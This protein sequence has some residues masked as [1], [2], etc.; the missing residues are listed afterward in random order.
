MKAVRIFIGI[1][2]LLPVNA[3]PAYE[4]VE[5]KDGGTISGRV[6][7]TGT[8]PEIPAIRVVKNPEFCGS[9][10]RD[11]VLTVHPENGGLKNVIVYLQGI[12]RGKPLP[13][14]SAVNAFK[15]LFVPYSSVVLR[16][17]PVVFHNNDTILHNA[18]AYNDRG[19]TLFNVALPGMGRDVKKTIKKGG[20]IQIQCDSHV[21][22]NGWAISLDHPYFSV[23]DDQ[24]RFRI[25]DIPPGKYKLVAWHPG[26]TMI[27]RAAY[28][29]SL[30][31]ESLVRPMYDA[32]HV[33]SMSIAVKAKTDTPVNLA[34]AGR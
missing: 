7:F 1:L 16:G 23:T 26:Y 8:V 31:S 22:M 28:E 14:G 24:G 19:A 4:E 13:A 12:D 18:H 6:S 15:C 11:P 20:A 2:F 27:N 17:K 3:V 25:R 9:E 33:V 21:H 29:A 32:P 30:G 34:I 10:V 5:V